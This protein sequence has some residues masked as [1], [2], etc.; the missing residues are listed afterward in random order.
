MIPLTENPLPLTETC[1]TDTLVESLFVSVI[2]WDFV[3]PMVTL[4]N[5]SVVGFSCSSPVPSP[6]SETVALGVEPSLETVIVALNVAAAFGVKE[7]V[8]TT[9]C[10]GPIE[11]GSAGEA[12]VKYFVEKETALMVTVLFPELLADRARLL[13]VPGF[14]LPKFILALAKT[15]LP[16]C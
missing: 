3:D 12:R 8:N 2:N 14:T 7:M 16:T 4:P 9:L 10:P 13:L 5:D 15:R 6:E 11:A 1:E